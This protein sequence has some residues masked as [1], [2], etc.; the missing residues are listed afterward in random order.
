MLVHI[1]AK[2]EYRNSPPVTFGPLRNYLCIYKS[3]LPQE[4]EQIIEVQPFGMTRQASER[5]D[6]TMHFGVADVAVGPPAHLHLFQGIA[7]SA[8]HMSIQKDTEARPRQKNFQVLHRV[9]Q[10]IQ[11]ADVMQDVPGAWKVGWRRLLGVP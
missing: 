1:W 3:M 8:C 4:V 6:V 7:I 9:A 11:H 5:A 10:V 2:A